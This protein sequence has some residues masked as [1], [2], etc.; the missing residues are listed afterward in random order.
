MPAVGRLPEPPGG[1]PELLAE[2][3]ERCG[4]DRQDRPIR[5]RRLGLP[6]RRGQVGQGRLGPRLQGLEAALDRGAHRLPIR[7]RPDQ[8]LRRPAR[9]SRGLMVEEIA[10]VLRQD[11]VEVRTAEAEGAD[12]R[13]AGVMGAVDPRPRLGVQVQDTLLEVPLGVRRLD[14]GRR[15]HAVVQ[16][17]RRLDQPGDARGTLG[18]PDHGLDRA[19]RTGLRPRPRLAHELDQRLGLGLVADHGARPVGLD[20]PDLTRGDAGLGVG[21]PQ[22]PELPLQAGGG[23]ALVPAVAGGPH[24][25]DDRI[26]AVAVA[27]GISQ[28]LEDD[29]PHPFAQHDAVGGRVERAAAPLRGQ[30]VCL[31]EGHVGVGGLDRV[32]PQGDGH[33]AGAHLQLPD[34]GIDGGQRGAA[35]GVDRVV[36]P[37]QVEPVGDPSHRHIHQDARERVLGPL[38]H[39]R[40]AL[41]HQFVRVERQPRHRLQA[42]AG[43]SGSRTGRPGGCRRRRCPGSRP[44]V[45]EGKDDRSNRRRPGHAARLRA[46]TVG[47]ARW[48]AGCWA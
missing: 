16:G 31:A 42:A 10:R 22:G 9:R 17:Q 32:G 27:L 47:A 45:P 40:A 37:P 35:G 48:R 15:E 1:V 12:P 19:H 4:D 36:R 7:T 44:S 20:Q 23:Q 2:V 29:G 5:A 21:P 18:V 24:P 33:V 39:Q 41:L 28:T 46:R 6:G 3:V 30:C 25:L 11:G 38:G 43:R 14:Q 8:Q 13:I 26:D 34:A